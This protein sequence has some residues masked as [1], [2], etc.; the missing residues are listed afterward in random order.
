MGKL[1]L[2]EELSIMVRN[3]AIQTAE[4]PEAAEMLL[5]EIRQIVWEK[6]KEDIYDDVTDLPTRHYAPDF[7]SWKTFLS[8]C[9]GTADYKKVLEEG[10][11]EEQ[12]ENLWQ[13]SH[14]MSY[15]SKE[16]VKEELLNQLDQLSILTMPIQSD[17]QPD[18]YETLEQMREANEIRKEAIK[19][20]LKGLYN[21]LMCYM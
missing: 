1:N 12:L 21:I 8:A 19:L 5:Q 11:T 20:R 7:D 9:N 13:T 6:V 14:D 16:Q 2:L 3:G 18:F 4:G 17:G 15:V 10:Y